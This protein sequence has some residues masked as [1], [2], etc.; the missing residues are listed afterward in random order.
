VRPVLFDTG[1]EDWRYAT[2]GGTAF[3]VTL[4]ERP[5]ALTCRH[6]FRD[7]EENQVVI[8]G[9]KHAQ[10]G[11]KPAR[12]QGIYYPS[13]PRASAIDTDVLDLCLIEFHESVSNGFFHE[14]AFAFA[15]QSVCSSA[16]GD[17]LVLCG[18][19]KEK[20]FI[21]P[22]N[23]TIGYCRLELTDVR[24]TSDPILR[25][26]AA[27]YTTSEFSDALG[28]SGAPLFNLTRNGLRGMAIR[29][30]FRDEGRLALFYVEGFDLLRFA[31]AA[32]E[33]RASNFY[34]KPR[35]TPGAT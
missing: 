8:F 29:G 30:G 20:T 19:L 18:A 21:D 1:F 23:I 25:E 24:Q 11:D 27:Q 5:Y 12:F 34:L 35:H 15:K 4:R 3:V 10:K 22:P 2:H 16:P 26:A 33:G 6:V 9:R 17:K 31:E 13:L 14:S 28:L 32:S 7:F